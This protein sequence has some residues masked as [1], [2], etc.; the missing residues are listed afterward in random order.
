MA[1]KVGELYASFGID[2]S[3]VS[4]AL[5]GIQQQCND[6]AGSLVKTGAKLGVAVTAPLVKIGKE[7]FSA[8]TGFDAQMSRVLAIS[9]ATEDEFAQL[10]EAAIN[11][12]STT[13]FTAQEAGEALQY[14]AMAG[15]KA[16]SMLAGLEPVMDLA[17]ASGE[18]LGT[19]SDIVT[20]AMTAFG[21]TLSSVN[22]DQQQFAEMTQH[23]ADVLAATATNSNTNV[24][25]LGESFKYAAAM[26]GSFGYSADDVAIALGLMANSGVKASMAGTSL[27]NIMQNML[28]PSTKKMAAAMD[29]LG[30]S[31]TNSDG[32]MKSF[33]EVMLDMRAAAAQSGLDLAEMQ[34]KVAELDEQLESGKISQKKYDKQLAKIT[35]GST[36]FMKSVAALAGKRGL[37][38]ML[39]IMNASDDD[40]NKLVGAIDN[41][42]GRADE[43]SGTMLDNTKGS[44]TL[45]KSAV[46][47]LEITLWSLVSG[48][49]SEIIKEATNWVNAFREMG[50]TTQMAVLKFGALAAA[51]GP[52]MVA[53]GGIV[54]ALGGMIPLMIKLISPMGLVAAGLAFFAIA[55]IDA[56]NDIGKGFQKITKTLSKKMKTVIKTIRS[57]IKDISARMPE[58]LKSIAQGIQNILPDVMVAAKE[59]IVGFMDALADN[60]DG[61]MKI[62]VTLITNIVSGL[63][64]ALPQLIPAAARMLASFGT[65]LIS[66]IP[67]L[68]RSL[69][70]LGQG[71]VD[72]IL[73]T[74]WVQLGKDILTAIGNAL[75]GLTGV[76]VGE[77]GAEI[78]LSGL[79]TIFQAAVE[80]VK[81]DIVGWVTTYPWGDLWTAFWTNLTAISTWLTENELDPLSLISKL[82]FA[83]RDLKNSLVNWF[84]TI[85]WGAVWNTFWAGMTAI[86]KWLSDNDISVLSIIS[87][88][89]FA[90]RDIK[91]SLVAWFQTIQ[92]G[93]VWAAFWDGLTKIGTWLLG[94][95]FGTDDTDVI[96]TNISTWIE[97]KKTDLITWFGEIDWSA[98]WTAFWNGLT[99]IGQWLANGTIAGYNWLKAKIDDWLPIAQAKVQTW[100][101]SVDWGEQWAAFWDNFSNVDTWL[102]GK[103][104]NLGELI[105][106]MLGWLPN[107][108]A[109]MASLS[110]DELGDMEFDI[111]P[112]FGEPDTEGFAQ[113]LDTAAEYGRQFIAGMISGMVGET[114]SWDEIMAQAGEGWSQF[115]TDAVE[116]F[117]T[118]GGNL[119]EGLKQGF[120][121]A[122]DSIVLWFKT[123]INELFAGIDFF[124]YTP[125]VPFPEVLPEAT[126][127]EGEPETVGDRFGQ[128][129]AKAALKAAAK[130]V[131]SSEEIS[132]ELVAG[133]GES[134]K[135][136]IANCFKGGWGLDA[137]EGEG[138]AV[139]DTVSGEIERKKNLFTA[140]GTAAATAY[141][142]AINNYLKSHTVNPPAFGGGGTYSPED[143]GN[144]SLGSSLASGF[145]EAL[146]MSPAGSMLGKAIAANQQKDEFD[147][148]RLEGI[149]QRYTSLVLELDGRAL[150]HGTADDTAIAQNERNRALALRY[151]TT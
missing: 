32:S 129:A 46:E 5:S 28:D 61:L 110:G 81:N 122:W 87:K 45:F 137:V 59:I 41:A 95:V 30:L 8:G 70:T 150:A 47:G 19:V 146:T 118:L 115:F 71:I 10:R 107:K 83:I 18:D 4:K 69:K 138:D 119:I 101:S 92:W 142:S 132:D 127:S 21:M 123:K 7:I 22:G 40:F 66:N 56:N 43:M 20:D 53:M 3:G 108:V 65:A 60:A 84:M 144:T 75:K 25:M 145:V 24:G 76:E 103:T 17:A 80:K 121:N 139:A 54:K 74:D 42:K 82:W 151:G 48:P 2:T 27:R 39:A 67:A 114:L 140:A 33:R 113:F 109:D 98:V 141:M 29:A 36:D 1:L 15:W 9:G 6:M 34:A 62:G 88:L 124:G 126:E 96:T 133:V 64:R 11:M 35:G 26:A 73:N 149:L 37:A 99:N 68:F 136:A 125:E 143:K 128:I 90:I 16:D 135:N 86:G 106:K 131:G 13:A 148:E 51:A 134:T 85:D 55:A 112:E 111:T 58:L 44:I 116:S 57:T 52:V 91:D 89:W 104:F 49:I 12:G 14:M 130:E 93:E 120:I 147:Y 50:S 72:G 77:E 63:G 100:F 117:K 94:L 31:M 79:L 105:G 23:F 78:D 38:G 102:Q 97:G